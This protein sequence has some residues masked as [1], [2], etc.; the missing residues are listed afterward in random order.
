MAN[1]ARQPARDAEILLRE[2]RGPVALLTLNRPEARN[3]LSREL[4]EAVTGTMRA[5]G[6]S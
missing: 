2:D 4:I 3:S 1:I 6:D 5:I